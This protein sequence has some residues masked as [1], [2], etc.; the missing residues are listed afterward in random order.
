MIGV[1][2]RH[3]RG[4][5]FLSRKNNL[6]CATDRGRHSWTFDSNILDRGF[7]IIKKDVTRRKSVDSDRCRNDQFPFHTRTRLNKDSRV[8]SC[9]ESENSTRIPR[10]RKGFLNGVIEPSDRGRR[11]NDRDGRIPRAQRN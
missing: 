5:K 10:G 2:I 6:S 8:R 1:T 9:C 7:L 4:R 11:R 3:I